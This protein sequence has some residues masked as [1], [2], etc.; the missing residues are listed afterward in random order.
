MGLELANVHLGTSSRSE[1]IVRDLEARKGDWL[2]ANAKRAAAAVA[3]DFEDPAGADGGL[4]C[5]AGVIRLSHNTGIF[6]R[7]HRCLRL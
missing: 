4:R 2:L 5:S 7:Q 6:Q 1:A 3:R